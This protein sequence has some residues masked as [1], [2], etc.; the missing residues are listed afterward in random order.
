MPRIIFTVTDE[1]QEDLK[2]VA[3]ER[4]ASVSGLIRLFI[5]QALARE[6]GKD[7][8]IYRVETGGKRTSTPSEE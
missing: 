6:T 3:D 4:G 1:M 5:V 2:R 7:P 8:E